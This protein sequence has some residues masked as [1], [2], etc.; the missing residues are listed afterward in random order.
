[1]RADVE[2]L[3]VYLHTDQ[4]RSVAVA[5]A[6][7]NIVVAAPESDSPQMVLDVVAWQVDVVALAVHRQV[8]GR[9]HHHLLHS[10]CLLVQVH[11]SKLG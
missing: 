4:Q 11:S 10:R 7:H 6:V 5:G 2:A 1:M 3:L 8:I 9:R